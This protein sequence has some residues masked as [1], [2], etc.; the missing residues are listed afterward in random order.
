VPRHTH[1]AMDTEHRFSPAA[2]F[3][4]GEHAYHFDQ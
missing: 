4:R 3:T 1:T 2:I